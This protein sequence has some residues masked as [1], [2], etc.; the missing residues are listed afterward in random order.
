MWSWSLVTHFIMLYLP[1]VLL[2]PRKQ[3]HY[4]STDVVEAYLRLLPPR[5]PVGRSM[6]RPN[7]L[8][9]VSPVIDYEDIY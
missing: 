8:H 7:Y 6:N 9:W 1:V 5:T 2:Y 3:I 4:R